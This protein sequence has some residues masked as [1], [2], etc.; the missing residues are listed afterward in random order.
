MI[1]ASLLLALGLLILLYSGL[2]AWQDDRIRPSSILLSI[3]GWA[4]ILAGSI[5]VAGA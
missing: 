3:G 4:C 1:M 2:T 5:L